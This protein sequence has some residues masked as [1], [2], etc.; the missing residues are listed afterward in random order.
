MAIKI[1]SRSQERAPWTMDEDNEIVK[2]LVVRMNLLIGIAW[3]ERVSLS[4]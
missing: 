4:V 1:K 3:V 2:F